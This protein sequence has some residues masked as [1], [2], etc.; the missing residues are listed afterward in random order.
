LLCALG[1]AAVAASSA[2]GTTPTPVLG[3][4]AVIQRIA[5]K[6]TFARAGSTHFAK[7]GSNPTTIPFGTTIAA[8]RGTVQVTIA[9]SSGPVSAL[10][11]SGQ[12]AITQAP[13]GIATLT[14]NGPL[15]TCPASS[16]ATAARLAAAKSAPQKR[17]LWGNGGAGHFQ[18]KGNYAA[19]TVLGT[20]WLTTDSCASTV[21]GVAEGSVSV[22]DLVTNS[23]Q[24]V[25]SDQAETVASAGTTSVAPFSGPTTPPSFGNPVSIS[26][27]STAVKLGSPYTLT[28][29]GVAS[30][31][32]TAYIYE[33]VGSPCSKTLAAERK[34]S[35]A[36]EFNSESITA[37]G[38]F[39]LSA[40]ALAQ[41]TGTKYYCA[42][43]TDPAAY[44]QVIVQVS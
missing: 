30:G 28:A 43:L 15:E 44:A 4:S 13:T 25:T 14:L 27:S 5:G 24:T 39:T 32:G 20:V 36:F 42:Y 29:T 40:P 26:S 2:A 41:H 21:V 37:A 3:Q 9:S 34:N 6:V 23:T 18:T 35:V 8:A 7:L 11:Y 1:L 17:S 12:F 33:N 19:A 22:S 31:P 10:F 38:A 16:G